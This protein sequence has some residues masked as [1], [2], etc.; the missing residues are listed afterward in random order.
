[1]KPGNLRGIHN[2]RVIE[3]GKQEK[4]AFIDATATWDDSE[5]KYIIEN[6]SPSTV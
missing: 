5:G 2:F 1:M 6:V 3:E 4:K